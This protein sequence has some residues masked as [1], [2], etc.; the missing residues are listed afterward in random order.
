MDCMYKKLC[1]REG[2]RTHLITGKREFDVEILYLCDECR[3]KYQEAIKRIE[4]ESLG[5]EKTREL[6][7]QYREGKL[8][9]T[10]ITDNKILI[11]ISS[12]NQKYVESVCTNGGYTFQTYFEHL[13]NLYKRSLNEPLVQHDVKAEIAQ[14]QEEQRKKTPKK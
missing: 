3:K 13:L 12:E 8:T 11:P 4:K 14:R 10:E 5:E 6:L 2:K 7:Q 1:G 9:M